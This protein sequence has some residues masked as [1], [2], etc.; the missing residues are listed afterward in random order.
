MRTPKIIPDEELLYLFSVLALVESSYEMEAIRFEPK[1]FQRIKDNDRVL[2]K[3][4]F[5]V[6]T[7]RDTRKM[8][9]ATSYGYLQILG[10]NLVLRELLSPSDLITP[11]GFIEEAINP[12]RAYIYLYDFM[13]RNRF[14]AGEIITAIEEK[15][16]T[17][18]LIRFARLWNGSKAYTDTLI[19]NYEKH[20]DLVKD[21][22]KE[23]KDQIEYYSQAL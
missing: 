4:Q 19:D 2:Q 16:K 20:K 6:Y 21:K 22:L 1:F 7:S 14:K 10:Y 11:I 23:L 8:L 5:S 15:T 3:T 9:L 12:A 18:E 13:R 17:K